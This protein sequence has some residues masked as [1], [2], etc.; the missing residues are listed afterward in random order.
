LIEKKKVEGRGWLPRASNRLLGEVSGF[1]EMKEV[2]YK[3]GIPL[4]YEAYLSSMVLTTL[5]ILPIGFA[6]SWLIHVNILKLDPIQALIP[7]AIIA[8]VCS[9]LSIFSFIA[10]PSY[11]AG[12]RRKKIDTDLIYTVGYSRILALSGLSAESIFERISEVDSNS[13]IRNMAKR[14]IMDI[15]VFGLDVVSSLKDLSARSASLT[16]SNLIEGI[17]NTTKASGNLAELFA[18]EAN[19]LY[20]EKLEELNKVSGIL[21]YLGEIYVSL[22]VVSPI[23]FIIMLTI[24]SILGGNAFSLP[25]VVQINI[26]VFFGIPLMAFIFAIILDGILHEEV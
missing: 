9:M 18:F 19:R 17:V 8:A 7:S 1:R 4:I 22:I 21:T 11:R 26:L 13:I 6:S 3:A 14:I 24:L 10:Y 25:P 15:K 5:V 2:Y 16:F 23:V 20:K 12:Q